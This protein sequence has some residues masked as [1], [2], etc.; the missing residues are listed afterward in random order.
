MANRAYSKPLLY[1][2][3]LRPEEAVLSGCKLSGVNMGD[4]WTVQNRACWV[5][6]EPPYIEVRCLDK[7]T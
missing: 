1:R 2:V 5:S 3:D 7:G 6:V 4:N